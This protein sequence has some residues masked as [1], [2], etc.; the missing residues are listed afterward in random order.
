[1]L[2]FSAIASLYFYKEQNRYFQ[3]QKIKNKLEFIECKRLNKFVNNTQKCKMKIVVI[4]DKIDMIFQEIFLAFLFSLSFIIPFSYILTKISLKPMRDS[5]LLMDGFVNGIVHDINTPLSVV[6]M[7][8]QSV[9]KNIENE[10]LKAKAKRIMQGV[11]QIESLEEQLLFSLRIG[12]YK[13]QKEYFDIAEILNNR[14]EYWNDIRPNIEVHVTAS[15]LV[16]YAD[17]TAIIR[18]VDNIV[19]NAIKYS[20]SKKEV[21][22]LLHN[23]KLEIIDNGIGIKKPKEIFQKYYRESIDTKGIGIGLYIV[24]QIVKLHNINIEVTSEIDKG[25][26]FCI[27]LSKIVSVV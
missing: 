3:E 17:K 12:Q 21:Q 18:M 14:R 26:K 2:L 6:K 1:M 15:K 11:E 22:I 27:D 7:N 19:N 13:L 25:S 24:A 9:M 10:K 5:I 20:P 16:L 8:A 4:K 23:N